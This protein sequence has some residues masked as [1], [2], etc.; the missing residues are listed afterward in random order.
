MK[1]LSIETTSETASISILQDEEVLLEFSF[2]DP[3]VASRLVNYT[4]IIL[5]H[6]HCKAEDLDL[7]VISRGP[8]LWT[9]I[10]LGMGFAK[11]LSLNDTR[12]YCVDAASSLFFSIRDF[13][14]P[15][16][17]LVNAYR[18]R[19]YLSFFN[20]RFSYSK[21]Y[22]VKTVT[23]SELYEICKGE[24]IFLTG[25]GIDVLPEEIKKIKTVKVSTG[26]TAYPKAGVNALL[27]IERIKR[28]IPSLP[29]RPFYGR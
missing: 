1:T 26:W 4:D 20:G 16:L 10:R 2:K 12:I 21:I 18:E 27:A 3:D 8:G 23:Y 25:P 28:N 9:G 5:K 6:I 19:M 29:L 24:K 13:K 22:S 11:G 17:C 15:S 14:M 7:I